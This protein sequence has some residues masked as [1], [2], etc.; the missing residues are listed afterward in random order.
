MSRLFPLLLLL[1]VACGRTQSTDA[2]LAEVWAKDQ[3]SRQQMMELTKA[4]TV[5]G[6]AELIDSLLLASEA[7]DRIDN[8]NITII[9]SLLQDGLPKHLAPE[10][11]KT[12]WIVIDHASLEKQEQYLPLIEQMAD[13]DLIGRDEYATLFDRIAMKNNRPQ[14]FGSQTVQFGTPDAMSFYVWPIEE[15]D[16]VDSLRATVG[17]TPLSEYIKQLTEATGI[18]AKYDPAISVKQLNKMR[19]DE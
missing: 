13:D 1:L 12:I 11:Y 6:R 7:V 8:E 18:E 19:Y 5:E 14:R 9:D 10:S 2:L 17:L 3:N 16:K 15:P 4:I